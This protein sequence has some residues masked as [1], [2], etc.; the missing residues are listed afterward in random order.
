MS[1]LPMERSEKVIELEERYHGINHGPLQPFT[2]D[3]LT[4]L[5]GGFNEY[6]GIY[7]II[8][9]TS[10]QG[11]PIVESVPVDDHIARVCDSISYKIRK[12]L[13]QDGLA[14]LLA[15]KTSVR[16][17]IVEGLDVV[18]SM[19]VKKPVMIVPYTDFNNLLEWW[20]DSEE[21]A[22]TKDVDWEEFV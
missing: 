10:L 18:P 19:L 1:E 16:H 20:S 4:R 15:G 12:R 11:F 5:P 17:P 7:R 6:A 9:A 3:S 8:M 2:P 13:I 21:L 14:T 22:P